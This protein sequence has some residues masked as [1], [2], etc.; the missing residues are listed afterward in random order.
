VASRKLLNV[1]CVSVA[2]LCPAAA[3]ADLP[4][5]VGFVVY[6]AAETGQS[7]GS[8]YFYTSNA[9]TTA[10]R[11]IVTPAGGLPQTTAMSFELAAG[12]NT[13]SFAPEQ[14]FSPGN[15]VGIQLYFNLSGAVFQPLGPGFAPDLAAYLPIGTSNFSIPAAG[16]GLIDYGAGF[17]S[18]IGYSG[19]TSVTV[20]D[21][22]IAI[23]ALN[24]TDAPSGSMTLSVTPVPA[25]AATALLGIG[26][27]LACRRRR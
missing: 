8:T 26:G 21:Y 4:H 1:L 5:L 23:S 11:Q 7:N 9:N 3:H 2:G 6:S 18:L 14:S 19:A 17:G 20:G 16:S 13:F 27:L 22:Q 24:A 25:P 12:D 15:F 10:S